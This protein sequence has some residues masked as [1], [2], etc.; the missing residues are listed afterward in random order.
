MHPLRFGGPR[1]WVLLSAFVL[2]GAGA[3]SFSA[4]SSPV[5]HLAHGPALTG[6][7]ARDVPGAPA[8]GTFGLLEAGKLPRLDAG[9]LDR[10]DDAR[11]AAH[12]RALAL[13]A[14]AAAQA[15]ADAA[16]VKNHLWIPALGISR[17]VLP[18]A[19]T[20][21]RPP[22]NHVFQ[23]GCAGT[24]NIYL[25]GHAYGVFKPLHDA[26]VTG[27]LRKGMVALY[28]DARGHLTKFIVTGW[29]LVRPTVTRW[30]TA[31]QPRLSMTLQS[32]IGATSYWRLN[33]RLV[34]V[35]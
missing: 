20:R 22:D 9:A 23:W 7:G 30:A 26:Y 32:C 29:Q 11:V 34:S 4:L 33:V 25:L 6:S 21:S 2:L 8:G 12:A 18:F 17:P 14:A 1:A 10:A 5:D 35:P 27:Q 28:S 24:N 19:C 31:A 16:R 15:A 13:A 3:P